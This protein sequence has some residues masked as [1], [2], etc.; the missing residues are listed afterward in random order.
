MLT[1]VRVCVLKSLRHFRRRIP[2]ALSFAHLHTRTVR[3]HAIHARR[4][5]K[6]DASDESAYTGTDTDSDTDR[7]TDM[8]TDMDTT[9]PQTQTQTQTQTTHTPTSTLLRTMCRQPHI[10]RIMRVTIS[11]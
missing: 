5:N 3:T 4:K 10:D 6:T 9:Q 1:K 11:S 8:D 2:L 7:D